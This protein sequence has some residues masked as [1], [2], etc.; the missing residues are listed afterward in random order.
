MRLRRTALRRLVEHAMTDPGLRRSLR[1]AP[2]Q[3]I[4]A[5]P[6]LDQQDKE[7]LLGFRRHVRDGRV[8]IEPPGIPQIECGVSCGGDTCGASGSCEYSCGDTCGQSCDVGT[9]AD[10]CGDS[11]D[12]SC[13]D[14]CDPSC[15]MTESLSRNGGD[16]VNPD[17]SSLPRFTQQYRRYSRR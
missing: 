2:A 8:V 17:P 9:C 10:S 4:A 1:Q 14:T 7:A 16:R 3:T 5:L 6:Y 11:C 13:Q 15:I 12:T